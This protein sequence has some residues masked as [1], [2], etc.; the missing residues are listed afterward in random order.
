MCLLA[1]SQVAKKTNEIKAIP[2]LLQTVYIEGAIINIYAID[3]LEDITEQII[4]Q[5]ADYI[6]GLKANQEGLYEQIVDWFEHVKP[7]WQTNRSRNLGHGRA[8][9]RTVSISAELIL[10]DA[11]VGWFGLKSVICVES[12]RWLNG[13]E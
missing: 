6:I 9:K 13:M 5:K 10:I 8:E 2:E 11:A 1:Q 3:C 12:T 4:K 7:T